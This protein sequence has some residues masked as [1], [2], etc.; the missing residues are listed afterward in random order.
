MDALTVGILGL[1]HLHPRSYMP[2]FKATEGMDVVAVADADPGLVESFTDEFNVRGYHNWGEMLGKEK[3]DLAVLFL[4]HV[5]CPDAAV[6]CAEMGIHLIVEKPM[7]TSAEGVRRM[8]AAADK[9]G[10]LLS[11]AYVWR[12]HPVAHKMKRLVQSGVLGQPVG[13]EGRCAAGRLNRYIEG[14]ASWMLERALS[15][16]GPMFNLG[17]HWIDLYRWMLEDEVVEVYGK[18]VKI[19]EEYDIEDNSFALLTFSGLGSLSSPRLSLGWGLLLL[20]AMIFLYPFLLPFLF[21]WLL[22]LGLG[23]RLLSSILILA[24]LGFLM[25]L[26]F[27]KGI[28]ATG[29]LASGL[30]PWAWGING[31]ASVLSSILAS[32][33]ALTFGFSWVLVCAGG[34]YLVGLVVFYPLTKR[35]DS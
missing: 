13:G 17:V 5:D 32:M 6:A 14:N 35:A 1:G 31:C 23:L 29:R 12:Y 21:R 19:N 33:G 4:P 26:P 16:G 8:V 34:A 9:A 3:L 25:G 24:P 27:P 7:A 28:A 30:I 20:G 10:V 22:G 11:T 18:N 2:H 15:G